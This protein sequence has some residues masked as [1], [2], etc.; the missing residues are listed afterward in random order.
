[1][2]VA[3]GPKSRGGFDTTVGGDAGGFCLACATSV[4]PAAAAPAIARNP[5]R[6]RIVMSDAFIARLQPDVGG[7]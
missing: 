1:V 2:V 5:R 4:R 6:E 3:P 7:G